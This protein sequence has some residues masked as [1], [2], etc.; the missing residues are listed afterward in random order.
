M[1]FLCMTPRGAMPWIL[2]RIVFQ[3]T[4]T[5][6]V[7]RK[8]L[9]G[10]FRKI[11]Q[12]AGQLNTCFPFVRTFAAKI[13]VQIFAYLISKLL[14]I[15]T[16]SETQGLLVGTMRYFRVSDFFG[17]KVYFKG[18]RAPGHFSLPN[19]FQKC[20]NLSRWLARKIFFWPINEEILPGNSVSILHKCFSSSI[21]REDFRKKR[22][23]EAEEIANHKMGASNTSPSIFLVDLSKV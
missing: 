7:S 13:P 14:W 4:R 8:V 20:R 23:D 6:V 17:A 11:I 2:T 9:N 15:S 16:S 5:K 19:E 3:W 22:F 21:E 10:I 18:W 1:P 12:S